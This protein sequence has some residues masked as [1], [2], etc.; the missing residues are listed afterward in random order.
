MTLNTETEIAS[1]FKAIA[2]VAPKDSIPPS[3]L[4]KL[5][6]YYNQGG[7]IMVS[8]NRVNGDLQTAQGTDLTT[9]LETWLQGK[10]S[11]SRR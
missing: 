8:I 2:I 5:D 10:G 3:H 1:R 7:K 4:A 11:G 9:G 6:A